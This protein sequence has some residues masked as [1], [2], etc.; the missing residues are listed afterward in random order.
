MLWLRIITAFL[1]VCA[2]LF[3]IASIVSQ[4]FHLSGG[5]FITRGTEKVILIQEQLSKNR[6]IVEND[7]TGKASNNFVT[8]N[9]V[10]CVLILL[11]A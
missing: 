1:T 10:V 4:C 7:R 5:Y 9:D 8:Y 11:H 2:E 6:M 3:S